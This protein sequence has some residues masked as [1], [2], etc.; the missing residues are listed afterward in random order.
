MKCV[1]CH[2]YSQDYVRDCFE[3]MAG[4]LRFIVLSG[5]SVTK[6]LYICLE[7]KKTVE[8][9]CSVHFK[10]QLLLMSLYISFV[11]YLNWNKTFIKNS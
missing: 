3:V 5:F 9:F 11:R 6:N 10:Q 2:N 4:L 8:K 7:N 1:V